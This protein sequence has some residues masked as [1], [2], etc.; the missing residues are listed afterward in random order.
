MGKSSLTPPKNTPTR[1]WLEFLKQIYRE[2]PLSPQ[3]ERWPSEDLALPCNRHIRV[4]DVHDA[5]SSV[6]FS[7]AAE[8][9]PAG[10]N[11]SRQSLLPPLSSRHHEN[12]IRAKEAAENDEGPLKSCSEEQF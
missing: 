1:Q 7:L 12:E 5:R 3:P 9:A 11:F 6:V 8:I 2:I 10:H 4:V